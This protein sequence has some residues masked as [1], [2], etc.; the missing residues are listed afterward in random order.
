GLDQAE[1]TDE[2][3]RHP[4]A[5]NREVVDR[6]LRRRAVQRVGG[7]LE[8]AHAVTLDPELAHFAPVVFGGE[9][10]ANY[11][12]P[13]LVSCG[14]AISGKKRAERRD[15]VHNSRPEPT[16]LLPAVI[17]CDMT[18]SPLTALSPLDGRYA[19]KAEPLRPIFSEF[20][21][22]HRRVAVEVRWLLAL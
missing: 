22:M 16:T 15:L 13:L 6:A 3:A 2:L 8:C 12:F 14:W 18:F 11:S 10:D 9:E 7:D 5:R 1:R 4:Q 17:I 21:L 20:G 19:A